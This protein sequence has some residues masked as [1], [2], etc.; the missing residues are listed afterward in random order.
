MR[1]ILPA[2]LRAL[3]AALL[4]MLLL[5]GCGLKGDLVLPETLP[6]EAEADGDG[7]GDR[8]DQDDGA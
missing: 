8:D 5:G 4:A 7:N 2:A 3:S 6:T 1:R